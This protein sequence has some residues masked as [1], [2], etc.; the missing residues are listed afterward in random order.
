LWLPLPNLQLLAGVDEVASDSTP[1][2][3]PL[4]YET[5][6]EEQ[7]AFAGRVWRG[8]HDGDLAPLAAYL[9]AGHYIEPALAKDIAD[10]IEGAEDCGPYRIVAVGRRRGERGMSDAWE[11][12]DRKM[13]IG[14]FVED[15]IRKASA[16]EFDAIV[17]EA[18]AKFGIKQTSVT[19]SLKYLRDHLNQ[20]VVKTDIDPFELRRPLYSDD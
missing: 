6:P 5:W 20:G 2:F 4:D 13:R 14:F 18:M 19:S 15:R 8:L 7:Q 12:H 11:R 3:D 17:A 16:G 10:S 9:R 1:P